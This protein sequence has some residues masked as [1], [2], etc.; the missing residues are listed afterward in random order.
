MDVRSEVGRHQRLA[1]EARPE[2]RDD[3]RDARE[4]GR[5]LRES[6]RIAEADVEPRRQTELAADADRQQAA[7]D[8][9]GASTVRRRTK[10]RRDAV[11]VEGEAVHRREEAGAAEAVL[12]ESLPDAGLGAGSRRIHHEQAGEAGRVPR[13]RGG[14][15]RLVAG[16]AGHDGGPP[17]AVTVELRDPPIRESSRIARWLPAQR[18][19]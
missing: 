6:E 11:V 7:V 5:D 9:D 15:G 12:A 8:E 1:E 16:D 13:H 19:R 18:G 17:H 4:S 3:H 10:D 2:V 14:D